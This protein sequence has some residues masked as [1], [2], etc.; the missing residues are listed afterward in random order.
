MKNEIHDQSILTEKQIERLRTRLY[1]VRGAIGHWEGQKKQASLY[2]A[3]RIAEQGE[4]ESKLC[5]PVNLL[6]EENEQI[7]PSE[8]DA[9]DVIDH[10]EGI[11]GTANVEVYKCKATGWHYLYFPDEKQYPFYCC[12]TTDDGE[13]KTL[14]DLRSWARPRYFQ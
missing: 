2:L 9:Y 1:E 4:I 7:D 11:K 14:K 5:K 8:C 6:F 13:F 10:V 3:E 12:I